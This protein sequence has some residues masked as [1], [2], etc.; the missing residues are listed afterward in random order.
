[1]EISLHP[2]TEQAR[3]GGAFLKKKWLK[4][5]SSSPKVL[6]KN[7][8]IS[9][10]VLSPCSSALK[11]RVRQ[12][13]GNVTVTDGPF[14]ETKELVGGFALIRAN[15][16]QEAVELT[17]NFLAKSRAM[18]KVKSARFTKRSFRGIGAATSMACG[19]LPFQMLLSELPGI[20]TS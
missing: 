16:K 3:R 1:M 12:E 10:E 14:A 7:W 4:W 13:K 9:T 19:P 11:A 15:S 2:Q 8:L 20:P 18:G 6:K 17:K 5:G